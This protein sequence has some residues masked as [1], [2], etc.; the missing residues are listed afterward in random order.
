MHFLMWSSSC[1]AGSDGGIVL[2]LHFS[3]QQI[4]LVAVY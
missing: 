1:C 4:N 3:L 2:Q